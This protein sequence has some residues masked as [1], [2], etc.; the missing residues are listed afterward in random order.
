M[1]M[2][3]YENATRWFKGNLHI[4]STLSDGGMTLAELADLY[5]AEGYD[6]LARIS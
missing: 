2:F 3:R 1:Q 4:H 5:A 6:F